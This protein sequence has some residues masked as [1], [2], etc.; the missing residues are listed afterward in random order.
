MRYRDLITLAQRTMERVR[1]R[2]GRAGTAPKIGCIEI[3]ATWNHWPCLFPQHGVGRKHL[4]PI[5][6]DDWQKRIVGVY[7]RQLLRQ[8]FRNACDALS[9][10]YRNSKPTTIS[11]ARRQDV[12]MLDAFIGPKS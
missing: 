5:L 10:R 3:Y 9:I 6:L 11:I 7:P 8:I 12:A 1:G 4:R 2:G